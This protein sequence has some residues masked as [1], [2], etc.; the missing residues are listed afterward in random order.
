MHSPNE[1]FEVTCFHRGA[2]SH[3]ALLEE[4]RPKAE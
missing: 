4:L 3:A 2:R 1:K